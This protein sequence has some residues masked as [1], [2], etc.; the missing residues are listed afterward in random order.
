MKK[1]FIMVLY[2]DIQSYNKSRYRATK[3]VTYNAWVLKEIP[4][5]SGNVGQQ[6]FLTS[7]ATRPE[8]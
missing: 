5:M 4:A 7:G 6:V 1:S 8:Q 3:T 2:S